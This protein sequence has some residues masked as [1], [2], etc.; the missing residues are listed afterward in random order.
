MK[1]ILTLVIAVVMTICFGNITCYANGSV[2]EI[3]VLEDLAGNRL[4]LDSCIKSAEITNGEMMTVDGDDYNLVLGL[5]EI[6][7]EQLFHFTMNLMAQDELQR[8]IVTKYKG[9]AISKVYIQHAIDDGVFTIAHISASYDYLNEIIDAVS[10]YFKVK[11]INLNLYDETTGSYHIPGINDPGIP[12]E[13]SSLWGNGTGSYIYIGAY[14]YSKSTSGSGELSPILWRVLDSNTTE[15]CDNQTMFLFSEYV[16]EKEVNF[17]ESELM[18]ENRNGGYDYVDYDPS[19]FS[20]EWEYCN[21]RKWLNSYGDFYNPKTWN[22]NLEYPTE[23]FLNTAFSL[24]EQMVI[25]DSVKTPKEDTLID[26]LYADKSGLLGDKIFI[27]SAE[28]IQ[29]E[30]YGFFIGKA[31][32]NAYNRSTRE[33]PSNGQL[34]TGYWLRSAGNYED[35]RVGIVYYDGDIGAEEVSEWRNFYKGSVR[36]AVNLELSKIAF[37][38]DAEYIK[39]LFDYV[40]YAETSAN[41][42]KLTVLGGNG[43]RA[44]LASKATMTVEDKIEVNILGFG[45]INEDVTY[46]QISAMLVDSN[47]VVVAYGKVASTIAPGKVEFYLPT[48]EHIVPGNYILKVFAEENNSSTVQ[49]ATDFASNFAEFSIE[50]VDKKEESQEVVNPSEDSKAEIEEDKKAE[51]KEETK[52]DKEEDTDSKAEKDVTFPREN[53]SKTPLIIVIIVIVLVAIIIWRKIKSNSLL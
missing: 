35:S 14:E 6:G 27:L 36:P 24:S 17:N 7:S 28:E 48:D 38:L 50:V 10:S 20:N 9:D 18:R 25:A 43:F 42:W 26:K 49:Y 13:L 21:L 44:E 22:G 5:S 52:K 1:K 3:L 47:N 23:G 2:G 16:M 8:Y 39:G 33:I 11:R 34:T 37:A 32:G 40:D 31:K 12:T 45:S 30:K 46:N 41:I 4:V 53:K 29:N 15:F 51:E 19:H